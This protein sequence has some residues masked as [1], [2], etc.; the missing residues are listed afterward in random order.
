MEW[1]IRSQQSRLAD[2]CCQI[3]RFCMTIIY[4]DLP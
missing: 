4:C 3:R 2:H 1:L